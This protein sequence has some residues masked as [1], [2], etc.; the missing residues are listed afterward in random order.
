MIAPISVCGMPRD[1]IASLME[2]LSLKEAEK[3]TF[4]L[5]IGKKSFKFSQNWN[6]AVIIALE[7]ALQVNTKEL[8]H[9]ACEEHEQGSLR[10]ESDVPRVLA[11]GHTRTSSPDRFQIALD[12]FHIHVDDLIN[13]HEQF[14]YVNAKN[15]PCPGYDF[16]F[17]LPC[18]PA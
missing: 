2:A 16:R 10:G 9:Y 5:R 14:F 6:C 1:S 3:R 4:C 15:P 18:L 17:E 13:V 12:D 11:A 8:Y 7:S